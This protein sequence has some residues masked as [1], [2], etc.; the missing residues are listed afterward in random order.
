M[1]KIGMAL[2]GAGLFGEVHLRVYRDHPAVETVAV[3]DLNI[4]KAES[5]AKK[6]GIKN[7][8][9]DYR[10]ILND[11]AVTAVAVVTPDFAHTEIAVAVL[12]AR[13]HLLLEKPM[14]T[15]VDDCEKIKQVWERSG[16]VFMV[17]FHN[18]W[19]PPFAAAKECLERGELGELQTAYFRLNDTIFVPTE[20]LA[21]AE[22]SSV[23]WFVGSHSVDTLLWLFDDD[24]ERVYS[25][26]GSRVLKERGINTPDFFE[27]V[28]HFRGGG[29][30]VLEN[31]WILPKST[32]NIIDLKCQLIGSNGVIYIDTSHHRMMQKYTATEARY[33]DMTARPIIHGR[34][35]GFATESIRHF[36]DCVASGKTPLVGA[37]EGMKVTR[38]IC[39]IEQSAREGQPVCI[40]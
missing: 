16:V 35:I 9:S 34:Q 24:V 14:A 15:T 10:E 6:Y 33:P 17:D 30:A 23:N 19:N 39:A 7:Y 3:C 40:T 21:W 37:D 29:V 22:K 13:R 12:E 31:A 27:S 5:L 38:I 32:P 8:V 4:D 18:R 1:A 2:V 20:M 36:L 11:P 28:L 26:S 25:V